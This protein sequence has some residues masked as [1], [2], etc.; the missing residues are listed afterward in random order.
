MVPIRDHNPARSVPFVNY[1]L[2]ATNIA[3]FLSYWHLFQNDRALMA[4]YWDWAVIPARVTELEALHTMVT[5]MFLHG[6]FMHLAG[7]MLFLFV[8]GDNLEDQLGHF[9]YL[10]FYLACGFAAAAAQVF[11][12]PGSMI[13]MVGA[14][15]A[16][17]GVMG[18]YMLL[19][20]RAR[21]DVFFFFIIFF[22]IIPIP[23]WVVLGIWFGLQL[24]NGLAADP[25]MG[26]VA[27]WA[28]AGGF[29]VGV[30]LMLP[31]FARLVGPLFWKRAGGH[32][33][34]PEA[35]YRVVR[36]HV[37][38]TRG[39]PVQTIRSSVPMTRGRPRR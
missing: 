35:R 12:D 1:M 11:T 8:F 24:F 13:P 31:V 2:L 38:K 25:S 37:P 27:Y 3:V 15:G 28:H 39:R 18:G 20:P 9:G 14:S 17:A 29:M 26:G 4:F 32:P 23:A 36:S 19:F 34:N 30:L 33:P 16:I 10:V 5:S 7:N 21:I 22:K 6:G